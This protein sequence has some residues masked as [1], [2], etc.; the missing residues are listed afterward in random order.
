VEFSRFSGD[1]RD[2]GGGEEGRPAGPWL[3]RDSRRG[4]RPRR[5]GSTGRHDAVSGG[6]PG[7]GGRG[8]RCRRD[9][10]HAHRG[11]KRGKR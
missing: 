7:D 1:F 9:L 4:G 6:G 11:K 2:G 8:G 3:A 10:R 5:C